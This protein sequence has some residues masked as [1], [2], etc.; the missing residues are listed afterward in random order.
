MRRH[1][2]KIGL[3]IN[4]IE[5]L[6]ISMWGCVTDCYPIGFYSQR[7]EVS[8]VMEVS[9]MMNIY[10]NHDLRNHGF[11]RDARSN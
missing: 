5:I 4:P 1:K 2:D 9:Q 8:M 11:G 10:L 7:D 6:K 3:L